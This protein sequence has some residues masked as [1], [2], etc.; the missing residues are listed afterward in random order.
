[1]DCMCGIVPKGNV[2]AVETICS[3]LADSS[4]LL[5]SCALNNITRVAG[6]SNKTA[7]KCLVGMLSSSTCH[8]R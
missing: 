6:R 8:V 4:F 1:M 5:T 7:L 2:S 3:C